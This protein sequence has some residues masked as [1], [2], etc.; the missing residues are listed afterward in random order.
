MRSDARLPGYIPGRPAS[1]GKSLAFTGWTVHSEEVRVF[2]SH[3]NREPN[4]LQRGK[5]AGAWAARD[6]FGDPRQFGLGQVEV[7]GVIFLF[8]MFG[9]AGL[10]DRE[11]K[12]PTQQE[13]QRYLSR[14]RAVCVGD[15]LQHAT[16]LRARAGEFPVTERTVC[17]DGDAVLPTPGEHGVFNGAL[18]QMVENLI[19]GYVA[20]ADDLE[21]LFEI[22]HVEVADAPRENFAVAS[23]LAE[24]VE[25]FFERIQAAPVQ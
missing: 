1:A 24:C 8:G 20:R 25:R 19:A 21:S 3:R 11:S 18:L 14:G 7:A 15:L 4:G 16:A 9:A 5:L 22:G 2:H 17:D 10:W 6:G 12:R 13:P 23:E